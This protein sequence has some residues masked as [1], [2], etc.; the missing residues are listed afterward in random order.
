MMTKAGSIC[1]S[2]FRVNTSGEYLQELRLDR[3]D[4]LEYS[5]PFT[6]LVVAPDSLIYVGVFNHIMMFHPPLVIALYI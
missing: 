3:P 1:F 2:V 6:N 5:C 4:T